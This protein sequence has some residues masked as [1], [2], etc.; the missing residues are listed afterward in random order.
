MYI[1]IFLKDNNSKLTAW[2][3]TMYVILEEKLKLNNG[4]YNN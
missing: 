2:L 3:V 1:Q 4:T